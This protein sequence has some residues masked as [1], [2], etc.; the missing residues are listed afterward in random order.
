[1]NRILVAVM[2]ALLAVPALAD[3]PT[4]TTKSKTPRSLHGKAQTPV[5]VAAQI[6]GTSAQ[7]QV[8]FESAA[9]AVKIAI[10]GLDGL[11]V[12]GVQPAPMV[13]SQIGRGETLV[14]AVSFTPGPGRS[15]L[16]VSA[17]GKFPNGRRSTAQSF[18]IGTPTAEQQKGSGKIVTDS[19]GRRIRLMPITPQ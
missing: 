6:D 17:E 2:A 13:T 15:L 7:V 8:T 14:Y 3:G 12:T 9:S 5:T 19:Q 16:V 1:M 18:A 4:K 10:W 11:T